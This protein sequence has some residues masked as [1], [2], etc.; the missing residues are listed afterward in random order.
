MN[1]RIQYS[2][3]PLDEFQIVA[4]IR[5][6]QDS[7]NNHRC[8]WIRH[9]TT[10]ELILTYEPVDKVSLPATQYTSSNHLTKKSVTTAIALFHKG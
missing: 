9:A 8:H 6:S 7:Q 10:R 5:I 2:D 3:E 4:E 1:K